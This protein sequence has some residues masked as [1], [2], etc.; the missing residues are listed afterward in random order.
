[1][2]YELP[3]NDLAPVRAMTGTTTMHELTGSTELPN[4]PAY[5]NVYL[6]RIKSSSGASSEG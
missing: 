5:E 1:M 4:A 3:R 2:I 6:I